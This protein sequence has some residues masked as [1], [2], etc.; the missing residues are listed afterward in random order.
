MD[1]IE[2]R[3]RPVL[4]AANI[5][6]WDWNI[7]TDEIKWLGSL[8]TQLGFAPGSFSGSYKDFLAL[9]HPEDREH[10]H[11]SALRSIDEGKE[12]CTEFRLVRQD[13]SVR[14]ISS[15]GRIIFDDRGTPAHM[16]GVDRD[17]TEHKKAEELIRSME[18]FPEEDPFPILRVAHNG[19]LLYANR[20][21]ADILSQ[22]QIRVGAQVPEFVKSVLNAALDRGE[23]QE[24]ETSC[25][26]RELL[27][28]LVPIIEQNYVNLYGR[29]PIERIREKKTLRDLE[30]ELEQRVRV[31]TADLIEAK[32]NLEI[33][34]EELRSQIEEHEKLEKKVAEAEEAAHAVMLEKAKFLANI[35]YD[36]RTP[37]NAVIGMT[38]ILLEENLTYE[39]REFVETIREG[40]ES[41]L[42]VVNK[43]MD[44]SKIKRWETAI[45]EIPFDLRACIEGALDLTA[46][47]AE[48]KGLNLAYVMELGTVESVVGDPTRLLQVLV[49]LLDD[50]IKLTEK[51]ELVV[52]ISSKSDN[53]DIEVHFVVLS[54]EH[55]SS[56]AELGLS[57]NKK[58]VEMMRGK[59]WVES[60]AEKGSAVH[61]TV[62]VKPAPNGQSDLNA[63]KPHLADKRILIFDGNRTNRRILGLQAYIWGMAPL[64]VT[65]SDEAL[66]WVTGSEPLDVAL[67]G[68]PDASMLAKETHRYRATLPLVAL[69]SQNL[70]ID[71][72]LF[73]ASLTKPIK[74]YQLFD[75]LTAIFTDIPAE[76]V[77][78]SRSDRRPLQIL[79]AED[80]AM[81]QK[82]ILL[83][84]KKLGYSADVATNGLE[85]LSALKRKP[86]DVVLMDIHMPEMNGIEA[87]QAIRSSLPKS[88]QPKI[89]AITAYALVGDRERCIGVGMDDYIAKPI[90]M[91]ELKTVLERFSRRAMDAGV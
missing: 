32:E 25:G 56:G 20:A 9:V 58:L 61:F 84:L 50:A 81:N 63:A 82:V 55:D 52:K 86:Y 51:G 39:Q 44:F 66:K 88:E 38:S 21:A 74:P 69:G 87:A 27:F 23:R 11:R 78:A 85:V 1:E 77:Q 42:S 16:V 67:F 29:N 72:E 28:D 8:E 47:K 2:K 40:G 46:L 18:L 6:I 75:T 83:M 3:L 5:T 91:Y 31:R 90:N 76:V 12:Y 48:E 54:T 26:A 89:L 65:S 35:S 24:L 73:A 80:N 64:V 49:N 4:D 53:S 22:W 30:Y 43:I 62:M 19:T 68:G 10:I 15:R 41:M 60:E 7:S 14:W 36:L 34:N 45:K 17:I 37:M 70:K 13:G 71:L 57:I 33:I 59:I 79:L